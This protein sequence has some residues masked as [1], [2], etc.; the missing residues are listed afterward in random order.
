M[1]LTELFCHVD[2]FWKLFAP[3]W[4]HK[5]LTSGTRQRQRAGELCESEIMTLLIHFHQAS[6]RNFKAY[7]T[8][9]IQVHLQWE[10]PY[11]VSYSR[12]VQLTPR[13]LVVLGAYLHYC[14][15]RCTGISLIDA[16]PLAVCHNRRISQHKTLA[17]LAQRGKNAVDG[18]LDFKLHLVVND[19]GNCWPAAWPLATA[20]IAAPFPSWSG[21]CLASCWATKATCRSPCSSNFGGRGCSW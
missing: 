12:F 19:R 5:Q 4:Q 15:G 21:G 2:D 8:R 1:H 11:L 10:F 14:F 6:Y 16:T 18:F 20:M 13:V 9:Y 3:D 17:G 7:Y